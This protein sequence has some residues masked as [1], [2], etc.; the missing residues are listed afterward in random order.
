MEETI[1]K[2]ALVCFIIMPGVAYLTKME[3]KWENKN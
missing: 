3:K 2:I 1:Q